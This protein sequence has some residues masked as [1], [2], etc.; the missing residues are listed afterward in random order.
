MYKFKNSLLLTNSHKFAL[1]LPQATEIR[2][3]NSILSKYNSA[4]YIIMYNCLHV[5]IKKSVNHYQ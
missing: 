5:D 2:I 1:K 3:H 4:M